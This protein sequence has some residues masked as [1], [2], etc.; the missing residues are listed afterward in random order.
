MLIH[1]GARQT[2]THQLNNNLLLTQGAVAHTRPQ[3]EID[4]DDVVATHG[5]TVGQLDTDA[6]FYLRSRGLSEE[7]ARGLLTWA[8][9]RSVIERLPAEV[10]KRDIAYAVAGR[11]GTRDALEREV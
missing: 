6:I 9:A 7:T 3:L 1:E 4:H 11:L 2:E 8:F 10:L 5:S